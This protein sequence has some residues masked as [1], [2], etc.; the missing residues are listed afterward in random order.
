MFREGRRPV[1]TTPCGHWPAPAYDECP[2][3]L[4]A[5]ERLRERLDRDDDSAVSLAMVSSWALHGLNE[6]PEKAWQIT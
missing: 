3:C 4:L 2:L 1:T 6:L 5:Y